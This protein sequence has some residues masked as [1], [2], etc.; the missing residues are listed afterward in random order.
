MIA[1]GHEPSAHAV[2][3]IAAVADELGDT[4]RTI[5]I[6]FPDEESATRFRAADYGSLP[7]NVVFGT[8][9][10][11]IAAALREGLELK[12][13]EMPLFVVADTF[14]RI[15]FVRQGYTI[16]LGDRLLETLRRLD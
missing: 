16:H 5:L 14:N 7:E 9:D 2:N 10:G 12:S 15:V 11:S 6:L 4:G 3:D 8:D 13:E 1:P